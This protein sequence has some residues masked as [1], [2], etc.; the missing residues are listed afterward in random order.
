MAIVIGLERILN[1]KCVDLDNPTLDLINHYCTE[2]I[3]LHLQRG[4]MK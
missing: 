1:T 2:I 4:F 3:W